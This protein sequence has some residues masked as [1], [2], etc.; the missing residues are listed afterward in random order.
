MAVQWGVA[1]NSRISILDIST[2]QITALTS[3]INDKQIPTEDML[4]FDW[5][6]NGEYILMYSGNG[7]PDLGW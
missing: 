1:E 3:I 7:N 5:H 2:G 6:P 4:F